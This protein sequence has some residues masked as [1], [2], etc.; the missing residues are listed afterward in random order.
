MRLTFLGAARTVTGSMHLVEAGGARL[1]LDCGLH[2]GRRAEAFARNSTFAVDPSSIDAVVLSH[3]H[4]DHCGNLPTLVRRGFRGDVVCTPATRDLATLMLLDSARVQEADAAYVSQVHARRGEP[5]V[6]PLYTAADAEATFRHLVTVAY[7]RPYRLPGGVRLNFLD[8]GHILGSA[9]SVLD[10]EGVRLIF[11]GDLGRRGAPI[12]RD[13]EI[14][15]EADA[16]IIES[17]YGDRAHMP[18]AEGWRRLAALLTEA[19]ARRG[20][21]LIPAFALGRVQELVYVLHRLMDE[22]AIP[23]MPVFV[24]SPLATD[25]TEVFRIHPECFDGETRAL[26]ERH[27]DPFGFRRLRYTRS[28]EESKALNHLEGPA[29]IIATSGMCEAGRILHHLRHHAGAPE[30]LVLLVSFQAAN[31]LGRRLAD[32]ERHVR[33]LGEPFEVRA[34]VAT[35][36]AFSAHADRPDLLWW[37]RPLGGRLRHAFVVHGEEGQA[38]SLAEALRGMGVPDVRVPEAGDRAEI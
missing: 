36:E 33:I 19:T 8:A 35:L 10:A 14:A 31:T 11:T 5:P 24:D 6:V 2:Q 37:T 28:V 29:V 25:A 23:G 34:E 9:I 18:F 12:L 26:L 22:R 27:E 15:A 21:V 13:P 3:A 16:L 32:G 7:G 1:L 17:T 38:A 30:T 4:I 20:K